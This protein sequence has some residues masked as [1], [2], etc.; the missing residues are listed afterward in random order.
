MPRLSKN[1]VP[2]YESIKKGSFIMAA[3][4]LEPL[5]FI[6][7]GLSTHVGPMFLFSLISYFGAYRYTLGALGKSFV[8]KMEL[9]PET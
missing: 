9:I 4:Y 8:L 2:I 7:L 3:R 1:G 5:P 6:L